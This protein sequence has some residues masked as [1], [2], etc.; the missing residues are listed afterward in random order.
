MEALLEIVA[1]FQSL[2]W[3]RQV[4]VNFS[5]YEEIQIKN[6]INFNE[7]I[8]EN[9]KETTLKFLENIKKE[10]ENFFSI[11]FQKIFLFLNF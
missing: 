1:S 4:Q 11:P 9:K 8:E 10:R 5:S 6:L 2:E 7:N 3:K